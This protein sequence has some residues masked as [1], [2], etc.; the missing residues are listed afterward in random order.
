MVDFHS[1]VLPGID[2]GSDCVETSLD[3]LRECRRQGVE[4]LFATPHFYADEEDP[5]TFLQNRSEAYA[6]LREA[7]EADGGDFP[8]LQLGAEIY[9]FPGMSVAEELTALGM[10]D[11][12][13]LLI[14]P[15]MMPWRESMLDEIEQTGRNLK[16]IPVVAH[17]DRYMRMLRDP[18]L[19]DRVRYHNLL[20]Q[21]N[22]SY[23]I[24]DDSAQEALRYL[25]EKRIHF[26][27]SDCHDMEER[28]PNMG[29]AAEVI[30]L[31]GATPYFDELNDRICSFVQGT[32]VR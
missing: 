1:H 14:E 6:L 25:R 32:A 30:Q 20:V 4:L 7:M 27:G 21:V 18:S 22:A 10:G 11:T 29:M 31:D 8:R 15:P 23:F 16:R 3:M 13:F 17:V 26:I 19:I 9:F 28:S 5:E 12:P 2:D 24:R